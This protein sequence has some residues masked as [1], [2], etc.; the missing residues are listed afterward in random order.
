MPELRAII[1]Q[2]SSQKLGDTLK[3]YFR[4]MWEG[5]L[6]D[7]RLTDVEQ[8]GTVHD[9]INLPITSYVAATVRFDR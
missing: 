9:R 5:K 1:D 7:T 2:N 8:I 6:D 4:G 3:R